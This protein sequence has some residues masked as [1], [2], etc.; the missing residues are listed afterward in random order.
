MSTRKE[1]ANIMFPDVKE[2]IE[3]LLKKYPDREL[4]PV[5]SRMGPSPTGFMHIGNF[6]Q[7]FTSWKYSKQNNGVFFIRIEDTDQKR[8][9]EGAIDVILEVLKGFNIILD[10]GPIGENMQD[11]GK[12]GPYVQSKRKY[13]YN[14]FAKYLVEKGLA[15]PCR[16]TEEELAVIR[17]NQTKA[18]LI[19]GIYGNYSVWRNKTPDEL[20]KKIQDESGFFPVLRL[21]SHGDL[22]K[23]INF[24]DIIKGKINMADNYN[25]VVL[26]KKDGLP[27]Y[28]LAHVADDTLMKTTHVIRGEEW[29][30]SVPLHIQL[31]EAFGLRIPFYAHIA[32][33]L[34]LDNGNKRKLSKRY[35]PEANM[36]YF[37]EQGFPTKGLMEYLLTIMDS[38]FEN[39]RNE[40]ID[41]EL[42]EF[43]FT[44]ENMNHAGAL[45]DFIKLN[46]V[47]NNYISRISTDE[48]YEKTLERAYKY[49]PDFAKL[50]ISDVDYTKAAIN[51]ERHTPKDPKRFTTFKDVESQIIFFYDSEREKLFVNKPDLPEIF[52][53]DWIGK[54][55]SEYASVLDLDMSIEDWFV[56][57]KQIGKKYGFAG[58]NAEFKEGGYI[59]K[60]GD[61][62]MFLRIQLCCASQTPDLFSVM[63]VMGK[64][65][66]INRLKYKKN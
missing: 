46:S 25:D 61:L 1:V 4:N 8:E 60:I 65:R 28:H 38:S 63:R 50:M 48:L 66:V 43:K 53:D 49:S 6:Y 11:V 16:M 3:D 2:T 42:F 13:I 24:D 32:P 39:W 59:G 22:H 30:T 15:Y 21:R 29:L 40:N 26:L 33:L 64:E 36:K 27:T 35:D 9:V 51:I 45:F 19:P 58:N 10:E 62:A 41:K 57:L 52:N 5:V 56:Q 47:C 7:A 23:K 54:F 44:L 31:F 20:M 18:K 55:I 34:K 17:E 14:V 12:Y 37:F